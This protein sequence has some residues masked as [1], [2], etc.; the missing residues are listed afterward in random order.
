MYPYIYTHH[1]GNSRDNVESVNLL[2]SNCEFSVD[3]A[4]HCEF[5]GPNVVGTECK[6]QFQRGCAD[7]ADMKIAS[8]QPGM[9]N[10]HGKCREMPW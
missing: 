9:D 5:M 1:E 10:C 4:Q 3:V 2:F 7:S 8:R 6:G